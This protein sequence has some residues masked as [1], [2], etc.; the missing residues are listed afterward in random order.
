MGKGKI[1][2]ITILTMGINIQFWIATV[3]RGDNA[4]FLCHCWILFILWWACWFENMTT[5]QCR[6]T[7]I[8]V[9]A[10][11]CGPHIFLL[12]NRKQ[13]VFSVEDNVYTASLATIMQPSL[14]LHSDIYRGGLQFRRISTV[15]Q[16]YFDALLCFPPWY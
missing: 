10:K 9:C 16:K 1:G 7:D 11:A 5:R 15:V 14:I 4:A 12:R 2:R 6:V 3:Y 13:T 8:K